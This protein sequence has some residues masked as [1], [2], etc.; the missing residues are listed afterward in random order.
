MWLS[1]RFSCSYSS[2]LL[3]PVLL[4]LFVSLWFTAIW[5][6]HQAKCLALQVVLNI[7]SVKLIFMKH[8][9]FVMCLILILLLSVF[10]CFY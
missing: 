3:L 1:S 4:K 6:Y 8:F 7:S 9:W 5:P 2:A 10:N